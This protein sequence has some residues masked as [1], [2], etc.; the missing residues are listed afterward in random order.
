ME[1]HQKLN[2]MAEIKAQECFQ[3]SFCS[4]LN[5]QAIKDTLAKMLN[6]IGD[7]GMFA[8]Y[9]MH[10]ISHVDGM[11][12][13]LEKI[14]PEET[15]CAMT[16]ADWLMTVLAVYFHDLGMFIPQGEYENREHDSEYQTTREEMLKRQDIKDYVD[17]LK[18][19]T[20]EKFLYQEYVRRNHGKRVCEWIS[21]CN[22]KTDEPYK[23]ISDMLGLL[24]NSFRS[25]LAMIC[26]SHQWDSL[27]DHLKSVD[28]AY[29]SS[30]SE[31]VNLLYISILLR[32]ADILHM[33]HDR[34]PDVEYRIISPQNEISIV[35]WAKQKAVRSVDVH[36]E[37]DENG[38]VDMSIV[39]HSFE[40]QAKFTDDKGYFSFKSFLDG[41]AIPELKRCHE[42]C[43]E[44]RSIYSNNYFFPWYDI[45]T[46]RIQAEGFSK[47]KL[48]FEIDQQNILRLLTGHTLY[49]DSTVVLRELI[50]NAM[51]AGRLQ[52]NKGKTGSSYQCKVEV[53]WNSKTRILRIADNATGMDS[54]TITN[55]LLKVGASK[56]QSEAFKKD[57]PD[58]HSI[59]RFG[60]GLLTCFMISDDVDVYTLDEVEKE[61]HLL[62]IRNLNGEYLMRNDAD[63]KNIL[64]EKHGTTFELTVRQGIDMDNIEEQIRQWIIIPFGEITLSIDGGV[65][66]RIGYKT[67]KEAVE[68]FASDISGVDLTSDKFRVVQYTIDGID[69]AFLQR[70]NPT[71]KVWSLYQYQE[72]EYRAEAP[73]GICVE[74]IRVTSNTPG[75]RGRNYLVLANCS[76]KKSPTTNVARNDLEE[77]ALLRAMYQS[78]YKMYIDSFINQLTELQSSYS[79]TWASNEIS[80]LIDAFYNTR[81]YAFVEK[82]E[83]FENVLRNAECNAIDDGNK[84]Q[85]VSIN[86]IPDRICTIDSRAFS[87]AVSLLKDMKAVDLTAHGLISKLEGKELE[88]EPILLHNSLANCNYDL[89]LEDFEVVSI[90]ADESVRR[91]KFIWQRK[92][93]KWKHVS[94]SRG[95]SSSHLFIL[96]NDTDINVMGM[97]D[98]VAIASGNCIFLVKTSPLLLFFKRLI[99]ELKVDD[100]V[101]DILS[102][103]VWQIFMDRASK[104]E[105]AIDRYLKSE[106]NYLKN[107]LFNQF[108]QEELKNALK[109]FNE[110]TL[111]INKYYNNRYY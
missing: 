53:S 109:G 108:S 60:I 59:S 23:L 19:D 44:S 39:P 28:E 57:Y 82:R 87:S 2:S 58:F 102:D 85:I 106:E 89:F 15:K 17:G 21:N 25:D 51:D 11:L 5:L 38:K 9:T 78:I 66:I 46:S 49:N 84:I 96:L 70:L 103:L 18:G 52:D 27:P 72:S 47:S 12:A 37:K 36:Y 54:K 20:G 93:N 83:I 30:K 68:S 97:E 105:Q 64:E 76:G 3:F 50:Q 31:K 81:P 98:K 99:N 8:E 67:A 61:C 65:P 48:R 100:D 110:T 7:N 80:Y 13:L 75:I 24:D 91:I 79:I 1:E 77:G 88:P 33:T 35:E 73:I 41:W 86:S 22:T 6:H 16:P 40:I 101:L 32:S 56:Y 55:Y 29:G 92:T 63:V 62:K 94:I 43:E 45:D 111:N 71:M 14:I 69:V 34:T 4:S 26:Q 74:G 42:W 107:A 10:D 90:V 95:R 104:D